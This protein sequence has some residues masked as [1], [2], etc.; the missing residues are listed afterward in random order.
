MRE[1]AW[2]VYDTKQALAEA[3]AASVCRSLATAIEQRGV[4]LLA[5]SGG[6]TPGLFFDQLS[7]CEIDWE[8]VVVTLVDER[9]VPPEHERSNER[10]VRERLMVNNA[11]PARFVG[12][13]SPSE[14]V[15]AAASLASD[16]V[17]LWPTLPDVTLLGMGLDGHTAS[18]FPDA[19][20]LDR[21]FANPS[22]H[23][24]LAVR[25]P[26]AGEPRLTMSVQILARSGRVILH[27]EGDEKRRVL[28]AAL[29]GPSMPPVRRVLVAMP[30]PV[31]IYWTGGA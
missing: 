24:V 19:A 30:G 22:E 27:I 31:E 4:G 10:L 6:T 26:S 3:L 9:F 29:T 21:L 5:V 28:E 18:F 14:D 25:S 13:Y 7:H 15:D 20:D 8:R 16:A 17:A 11:R 1:P 12:L 2:H 23:G